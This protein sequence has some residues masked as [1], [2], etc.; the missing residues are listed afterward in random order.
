MIMHS[1]VC[2]DAPHSSAG[3]RDDLEAQTIISTLK[4]RKPQLRSAIHAWGD[5]VLP[6]VL[7]AHLPDL[8]VSRDWGSHLSEPSAAELLLVQQPESWF[9]SIAG[10]RFLHI[11]AYSMPL[12]LVRSTPQGKDMASYLILEMGYNYYAVLDDTDPFKRR[13]VHQT[14][15][16]ADPPLR[17]RLDQQGIVT[18]L[19]YAVGGHARPRT[20]TMLPWPQ[21]RQELGLATPPALTGIS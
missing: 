16:L 11:V 14:E 12:I 19:F 3:Y 18:T 21:F 7:E 13:L 17:Q 2:A 10:G 20:L 9:R 5:D 1:G 15:L 6:Q 8:L 4:S